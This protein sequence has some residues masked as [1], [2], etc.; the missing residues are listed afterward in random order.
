MLFMVMAGV[1]VITIAT[2]YTTRTIP[3]LYDILFGLQGILIFIIFIC[4]PRPFR[5]VKAWFQKRELCG[6]VED[7]DAIDLRRGRGSRHYRVSSSHHAANG[8]ESVPL[9]NS[10][11]S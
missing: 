5:T 3:I 9:N 8:K 2:Y 4:L 11:A 7:P 6:C 10:N 1:W